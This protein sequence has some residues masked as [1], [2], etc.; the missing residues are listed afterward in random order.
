MA[1]EVLKM[2]S[3]LREGERSDFNVSNLWKNKTQEL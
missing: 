2:E 1:R 3:I